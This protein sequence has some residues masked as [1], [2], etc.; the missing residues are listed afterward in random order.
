MQFNLEETIEILERTP[1]TLDCFLSGL[2]AGWLHCNEGAGTWNVHEVI[3]HLIEGEKNNWMPR[4]MFILKEG[5]SKPFPSFDRYSHLNQVSE[6]TIAQKLLAF[7][8]LRNQN[9]K[10]LKVQLDP[11]IHLERTGS[12]PAFGVVKV[13]ELLA[14]WAVH[15]LTHIS[16]IVR[17]MANRYGSDVGP[18][19]EYLGI[20]K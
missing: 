17:V 4:L 3:D 8:M 13:K 1:Q 20:I 16:Q 12:H 6:Q 15:D 10:A 11:G 14:T 5:E 9:L 19:R 7:K 18:W 2:S